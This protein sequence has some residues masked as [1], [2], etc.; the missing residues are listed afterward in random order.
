MQ[1]KALL[2]LHACS[3]LFAGI[4]ILAL[5]L[6]GALLVFRDSVDVF[7]KPQVFINKT[8]QKILSVDSCYKILQNNYPHAV[9]SSCEI[10]GN[11]NQAFLFVI[12]DSSYRWGKK[13]M[14]LFLHPQTGAVLKKRGGSEDIK[15][16]FMAWLSTFHSSFHSGKAGEWLL[17]FLAIVFVLSLITGIV[18]YRKNIAAVLLFSK[19]VWKKNNLHQVVGTWALIFNVM[20]G[21]TGFWMQRYV[22]KK[23]FYTVSTWVSSFK[24]SPGLFF[25]FDSVYNTLRTVHPDF[26]AHVIYFAQSKNG[27]TAVYGSN[28]TNAF[29]HSKK[30]ADVIFLDSTG[31][32]VKTRFINEIAA[33]DRYDIINSQLHMGK[34]GGIGVKIIYCLFG[35]SAAVLSISGFLLWVRR[36]KKNSREEEKPASN[37]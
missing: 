26:T 11:I 4:F 25:N 23:E 37:L 1:K 28:S 22:F 19:P 5:S 35:F 14:Q 30:F 29:I 31:A 10:P 16:N 32:L 17:G 8:D 9:I 24:P 15:N 18:L 7:Q 3:G 34:Y 6:S 36:K 2:N 27:N 13:A 20:I 12:Y 21:L 33:G